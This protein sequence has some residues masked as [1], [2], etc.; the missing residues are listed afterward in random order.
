MLLNAGTRLGPYEIQSPLGAG[1]MGEVY[2]ARDT[3]LNRDVAIKVLLAAVAN[4]PDRMARFSREAQVLASLNHPHIAQIHGLELVGDVR[5]LVMELVEGPTLA[6]RIT[7]G[8]ISLD[9]AL[10]I[11]KQIAEALGAAHDQ[12][13]VHRDLKPANIKVRPDGTVKVLDFGLA[14]AFDPAGTSS[15]N[16]MMSP[17]LSMHA[18]QAG[19]ILGTAAYMAPEQARGR[20]CDR[21]ADIWAFGVVLYEMLTGA[22]LFEGETVSDTL[23]QVLTKRPDVTQVPVQV[24]RLLGACLERDPKQRLQAIGDAP[25]LLEEA[26]SADTSSHARSMVARFLPWTVAIGC[27]AAAVVVAFVHVREAAPPEERS[28]RFQIQPPEK[29]TVGVFKLSPDGRS[30]VVVADEM[31]RSRLWVRRLDSLIAQPVAGTDGADFPFWS[32]DGAFIGF[33]ADGK[34]RK[35]AVAGG[36]PQTL[37]EVPGTTPARGTWGVNGAI[38][39]SPGLG[40]G[41]MRVPAAGGVPVSVTKVEPGENH[42]NPQFLTGGQR[43]LYTTV[44]GKPETNGLYVGAVDGTSPVRVLADESGATFAPSRVGGGGHLLIVRDGALMAQ[45]FNAD[46]LQATGEMIP[47]AEE[48][49]Y[50]GPGR[51]QGAF[52]ASENGVLAYSA[53]TQQA[54][55]RELVW[56]DRTGKQIASASP[57]GVYENFNLAPDEKKIAFNRTQNQPAPDIWALD[58]VRGVSTRLTFDPVVEN[59]PVWSPDGLRVLFASRRSGAFDLHVKAATGAGQEEVLIK[60]GTVNG[61]PTDWSRDGRFILYRRPG[62]KTGSDLWIAPQSGD[63]QPFPY[64]QSSFNEEEGKFSPDGHWI[65]YVSNESGREEVYVQAFPLSSEKRRISTNGGYDP[66]WRKD[67]TGLFYLAADRTLMA[68]EVKP[69]GTAFEPGVPKPLFALPG[70]TTRR[71]YAVAG[72]GRRFL[73]SKPTAD[74][75]TTPITI[76]LNWQAS[77]RK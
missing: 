40:I 18:T 19:V 67:G 43:F 26:P 35:V 8:P 17:T 47:L 52:A 54:L 36:P 46:L 30:L 1:G 77:L 9:E 69:S 16:A 63:Q 37:C 23:A 2:R 3:N 74:V 31:G 28:V 10:P 29:S 39:F 11:A 24:R 15:A 55:T 42:I 45:P 56:V 76:V 73:V 13:I 49:G 32:P 14:K 27:L 62:D 38:V 57:P 5:A 75:T 22:R 44:G 60:M 68:V 59:L 34:L 66:N 72:D 61:W 53:G 48:V 50:I 51:R 58:L 25:L 33:A 12:G 70:N 4:D 64:L 6:D 41:L 71:S 65:A 21:R 7:Q 20:P